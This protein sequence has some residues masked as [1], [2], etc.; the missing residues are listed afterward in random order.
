[1][2]TIENITPILYV[3]DMERSL[4]FYVDLLGFQT[5][6]GEMTSSPAFRETVPASC[7]AERAKAMPGPG[8][9]SVWRM[10]GKCVRTYRQRA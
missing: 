9:T 10:P 5:P 1:M 3:A 8:S 6:S 2:N 4:R 7:C